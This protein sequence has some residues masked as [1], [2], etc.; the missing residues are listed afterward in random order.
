MPCNKKILLTFIYCV[1][2]IR[3]IT[4]HLKNMDIRIVFKTKTQLERFYRKYPKA[5]NSKTTG[6]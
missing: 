4:K 1:S 2:Y 5:I 3:T 6:I